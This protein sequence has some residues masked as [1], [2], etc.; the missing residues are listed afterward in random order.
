[1]AIDGAQGIEDGRVAGELRGGTV[2]DF[3]DGE[4][5]RASIALGEMPGGGVG[6]IDGIFNGAMQSNFETEEFVG[7]GGAEV[8]GGRGALR[9]GV[10]AGAAVRWCRG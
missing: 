7:A 1:M 3:F 5:E 10:D 9:D 4:G 6:L 2:A 8:D